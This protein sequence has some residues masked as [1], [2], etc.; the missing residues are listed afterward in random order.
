MWVLISPWLRYLGLSALAGTLAAVVGKGINIG[1]FLALT[2][3]IQSIAGNLIDWGIGLE[4]ILLDPETIPVIRTIWTTFRDFINI[5]FILTLLVIAF[6]TI[7]NIKDYKASDLLPK[8]IISA[9]LVNFSLVIAVEIIKLFH[10]PAQIFLTPLTQGGTASEKLA[11]ALRIQELFS[12]LLNEVLLIPQFIT[13]AGIRL[14]LFAV[15]TFLIVWVAFIIWARIVI[16]IGLMIVSPIAWLG[17]AIPAIRE[18]SWG[19]WWEQLFTWG[20]I[21]IPLF[22]LIYFVILFSQTLPQQVLQAAPALQGANVPSLGFSALQ[23]IIGLLI[24]GIFVGGLM[25]IKSLSEKTYGLSRKGFDR[26]IKPGGALGK[27]TGQQIP[28]PTKP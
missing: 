5:F 23:F 6:S 9:L 3:T 2:N 24:I 17:Y 27:W 28:R 18:K 25:F 12:P 1:I 14:A 19:A 15:K 16:L 20:T 7:F 11:N 22:G 13:E 26:V 4:T 10:V 8:L 21:T